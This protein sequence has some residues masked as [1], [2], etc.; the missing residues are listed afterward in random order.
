M[1]LVEAV[2]RNWPA[3]P[4]FGG[5]F[6]TVVPHLTVGDGIDPKA[7]GHVVAD[8][9]RVLPVRA[10]VSELTLMAQ[11]SAYRWQVHSTYPLGG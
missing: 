1:E 5:R 3:Y 10:W 11:N 8:V 4:P 9:E 7:Y 2:R 6:P